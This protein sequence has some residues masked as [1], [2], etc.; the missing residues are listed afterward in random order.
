M[1]S[2]KD[3]FN[4]AAA[5]LSDQNDFPGIDVAKFGENISIIKKR[6]TFEHR[7]VL[8]SYENALS[9]YKDFYEYEEIKG[10]VRSTVQTIPEAAFREAVANALIHRTWDVSSAIRILMFDDKIQVISP[11][12]LNRNERIECI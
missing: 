11:G 2:Q 1:R 7:S 6:A 5:L 8:E 3:G 9:F 4:N 10:A 12:G